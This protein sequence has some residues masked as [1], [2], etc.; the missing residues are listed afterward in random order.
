MG[1]VHASLRKIDVSSLNFF[2]YN[3]ILNPFY[4]TEF[5][6]NIQ[7]FCLLLKIIRHNI[8]SIK[9]SSLCTLF[10]AFPTSINS[11]PIYNSLF[12]NKKIGCMKKGNAHKMKYSKWSIFSKVQ[13]NEQKYNFIVKWSKFF[14]S[15]PT[16][17]DKEA[18]NA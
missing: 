15:K 1:S 3:K 8:L 12:E 9:S 4:F 5:S 13:K 7:A 16:T 11:I 6:A 2:L 18:K 17:V 14:H 10:Q